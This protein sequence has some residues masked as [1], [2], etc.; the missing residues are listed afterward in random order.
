[1]FALLIK[2]LLYGAASMA[3]NSTGKLLLLLY[4]DSGVIDTQS[5]DQ[6]CTAPGSRCWGSKVPCSG[7]LDR[8]ERILLDFLDRSIQAGAHL[9]AP[10]LIFDGQLSCCF[11]SS[12]N[13]GLKKTGP[14]VVRMFLLLLSDMM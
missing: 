12:L 4:R 7:V 3:V 14:D 1:M 5:I 13:P 9:T 2:A 11:P 8:A 6:P 10:K